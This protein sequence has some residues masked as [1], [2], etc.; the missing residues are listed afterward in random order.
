MT[1]IGF[2]VKKYRNDIIESPIGL[3]YYII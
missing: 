2:I 1:T 3:V